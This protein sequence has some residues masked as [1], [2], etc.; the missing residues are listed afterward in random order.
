MKNL[1]LL[2]KPASSLCNCACDYCF[3]LDE[4]KNRNTGRPVMMSEKTAEAVIKAAFLYGADDI[5]F[6]FQGGEPLL[7]GLGFFRRFLELEKEYNK[8]GARVLNTVQT[9][10]TLIDDSWADF[11]AEN[12]ILVGLSLD[13]FRE[14]HNKFRKDKEG[15]GTWDGAVKAAVSLTEKNVFF[16]VLCVVTSAAAKHPELAFNTL[17]K[18]KYIQFIPCLDPSDGKKTPWSLSPR[19]YGEFL[20]AVFELYRRDGGVSV[21]LFDNYISILKGEAPES[22]GLSGRCACYGLVEADG[23]VYPCDFYATDEYR[24][25][26]IEEQGFD[27]LFSSDIARDFTKPDMTDECRSCGYKKLC[28]G[29]CRR[30]RVNNKTKYCESIKYFL[31]K[32]TDKL[33]ALARSSSPF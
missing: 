19:A 11:F 8:N 24:L 32:D 33:I 7:R 3:Y 26:N 10:G 6:A 25:G 5:T 17:K 12:G 2:I 15:K 28:G 29:G 21:R 31:D 20:H 1:N 4:C 18:Y 13:G 27:T 30:E 23:S 16:N 14:A 9:N 22:C